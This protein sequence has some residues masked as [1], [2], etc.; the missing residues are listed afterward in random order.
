MVLKIHKD[1]DPVLRKAAEKVTDFDFELQALI[2]NMI[3]TMRHSSGVGLA[4]PQIGV[5][6]Q[7]FVC[8]F[9]VPDDSKYKPFPLTVLCNP[10][11]VRSSEQEINMVEGCL[12]FPGLDI[13]V[14]RPKEITIKGLDRYGK[15]IEVTAD[16]LYARAIQ[17]EFDH[18][19]STLL[20]D[21]INQTK[22]VFIG[23]GSLGVYALEELA[24]DPQYEIGLVVTGENTVVSRKHK[25][26][27]KNPI[28]IV[29]E[30]YNLPLLKTS[31]IKD[32]EIVQ[33]IIDLKAG[34]GV[35][36]DFGQMIPKAILDAPKHGI[37][38]IHPSLLPKHR[39]PAPVQQTILDGDKSTGVTL[40]L[41]SPKMDAGNIISQVK[42]KLSGSETSTILK[43]YLSE[44]GASLL[45]N[46]IP[47]YLASD[48]EP[49]EQD[50][51]KATYSNLFQKTDGYVDENTPAIVV[52]RKVRAFDEWPKVYT[53]VNNKRI[54]IISAHF[55]PNNELEIDRVK[56]EGSR[57]MTYADFQNGYKITLT[58]K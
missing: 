12:S 47:Y 33:K 5:S 21:H 10:M 16:S 20:I 19:H 26:I 3:E 52:E 24:N 23:T 36:A 43:K 32:P 37:I 27:V 31:Q 18:L 28:E 14:K 54:Q 39:G 53:I 15:P 41:T 46:S 35:M 56:P 58:F 40:I 57:E 13:L 2:D 4:A 30:T 6:K 55:N 34:L 50:E 49:Y 29:A 44:I 9:S 11:I 38:N 8:E 48:L 25:E 22:V 1:N 45:L 42:V 17:H 7:I 51:I